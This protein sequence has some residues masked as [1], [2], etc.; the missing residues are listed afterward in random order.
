MATLTRGVT[1]G[2]TETITNTKL[3]NL[4]DLG[5]VTGI[6]N[7]DIASDAAIADTKLA[8]ITAGGKVRGESLLDLAN[9][10]VG[11]G[12]IPFLNVSITSIPNADLIPIDTLNYVSGKSFYNLASIP[13][14]TG[15][16][17]YKTLVSSLASGRSP[18]YDGTNNY[19]GGRII[20][21][22]D[23][24]TLTQGSTGEISLNDANVTT[25]KLKTSQGEVS[26]SS[27][28][29]V[30]LT[31]PG[32]EYGF[33][34]RVK[35]DAPGSPTGQI[36]ILDGSVAGSSSYSTR[37]YIK[38]SAGTGYAQQRYV[39]AS[40]R[41][42]WAFALVDGEGNIIATYNA[43]DHPMYGNGGEMTEVPHP[44]IGNDLSGREVVLLDNDDVKTI[45]EKS[46]RKNTFATV[47]NE[48]FKIEKAK[49]GIFR[50]LHSG[51]FLEEKPE[52]IDALPLGVKV[53]KLRLK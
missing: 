12:V 13:D 28:T 47:L 9:I 41:D 46:N 37:V 52:M 33:Y 45:K 39:T 16:L 25:A 4:V 20:P 11:A 50:P 14:G 29:G 51:R 23:E 53:R 22:A 1:Y 26:T 42:Y 6:E 34:P 19:V 24:A 31:L 32:G 7:N 44:F 21:I 2:V 10:P 35:I 43:P 48:G 8:D 49:S 38:T 5:G 17:P 3:H 15:L 18:I 40:G 36:Q 30:L 27:T